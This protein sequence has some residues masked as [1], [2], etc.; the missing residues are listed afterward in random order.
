M[1]PEHESSQLDALVQLLWWMRGAPTRET[2]TRSRLDK[3]FRVAIRAVKRAA[4]QATIDRAL[5]EY[6]DLKR[7]D[8]AERIEQRTFMASM[9]DNAGE[10]QRDRQTAAD[11]SATFY[12]EI[13]NDSACTGQRR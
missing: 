12:E 4:R 2:T 11:V 5:P 9:A 10:T 13:Y 7:G 8:G 6:K 3:G 1:A